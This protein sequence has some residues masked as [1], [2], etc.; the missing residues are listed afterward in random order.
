MADT[1]EDLPPQV[2]H[3]ATCR[4]IRRA[5]VELCNSTKYVSGV[6]LCMYVSGPIMVMSR[7]SHMA[8]DAPH[9]TAGMAVA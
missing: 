3:S 6:E 1:L 9:A 2:A 7:V 5:G 4:A 8:A